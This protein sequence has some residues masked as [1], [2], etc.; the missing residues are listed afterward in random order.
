MAALASA[1]TTLVVV[2]STDDAVADDSSALGVVSPG[3]A[4]ESNPEVVVLAAFTSTN[5]APPVSVVILRAEVFRATGVI[6]T[7]VAPVVAPPSSADELITVVSPAATTVGSTMDGS[8]E[9][10]V[11]VPVSIDAVTNA[12]VVGSRELAV[13]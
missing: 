13:T 2:G 6:V 8:I 7:V 1:D 11:T 5:A 3:I 12:E 4:V 9:V 10:A